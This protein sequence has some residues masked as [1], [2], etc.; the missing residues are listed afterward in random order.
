MPAY[1]YES[2]PVNWKR[3]PIDRA[4]MKQ[5]LERS[6]INGTLHGLGTLAILATT[7]S[8][9]YYFYLH[10]QWIPMLL[11]LYVHGG[12]YAFQPQTHELSHGTMFKTRALNTLFKRIF[13]LVFWTSNTALYRMSHGYHHRYTLHRKSEGEEV[14]PRAEPAETVLAAA[15]RIVDPASLLTTIYDKIYALF[16]PY[17]RN[18]RR[19]VWHRYVY[20]NATPEERREA[21]WIN[22]VQLACHGL[23][24]ILALASGHWFLIVVVTMP[25]FYGGKWYHTWIHDTMHVGRQPETDDFR[26][27]C[28]SVKLDPFSSFL[29]WHMEFHVEHH[30]FPGIPCYNLKRFHQLTQEHWDKPQTLIDAWREMDQRSK[31]L[32]YIPDA[33]SKT[34]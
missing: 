31:K 13:A 18:T 33:E 32:L 1:P 26:L 22:A 6:D 4:I 15:I 2:I 23:L 20:T 27:C 21:Y 28:R 24:A 30:T 34:A 10:Q 9:S 14:H 8:L 11:A 19:G 29:Y 25:L 5:C 7:G 16:I 3:P 17:E 12:F